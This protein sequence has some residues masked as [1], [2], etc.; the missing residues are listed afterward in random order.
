L[1]SAFYF[2]DAPTEERVS[3]ARR[4]SEAGPTSWLAAVALA[5]ATPADDPQVRSTLLRAL[6][7]EPQQ[8]ELIQRLARVEASRE[9]WDQALALAGRAIQLGSTEDGALLLVYAR[10]L[11]HAGQCGEAVFVVDA[12]ERL[13]SDKGLGGVARARAEIRRMCAPAAP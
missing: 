13:V 1:V 5:D 9:R 2:G 4:A 10:G 11:A 3:L 7:V 8:A 6:A 12:L